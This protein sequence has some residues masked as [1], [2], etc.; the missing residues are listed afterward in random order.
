MTVN[1][2]IKVLCVRKGITVSELSRRLGMSAQSMCGKMRRQSFTVEDMEKIAD[3]TE[4]K[5]ERYFILDDG[6]VI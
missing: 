5:F 1:E 2:Q 4:T 6:D 3:A